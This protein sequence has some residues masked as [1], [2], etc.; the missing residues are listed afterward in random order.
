[1]NVQLAEATSKA[2]FKDMKL[3]LENGGDV[4]SKDQHV[5]YPLLFALKKGKGELEEVKLLIEN[6]SDVKS[7]T[8]RGHNIL[9]CAVHNGH[10]DILNFF[11]KNK[12]VNVNS[13][14]ND[15]WT[16]LHAAAFK[17]NLDA[18]RLLLQS[19]AEINSTDNDDWTPLH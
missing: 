11:L 12:Y 15:G 2:D 13:K 6:G 10:L 4:N 19:G 16:P 14:D 18:I 1:M 17:G 5:Q 3:L 7:K 8:K 9:H